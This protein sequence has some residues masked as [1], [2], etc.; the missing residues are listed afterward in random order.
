MVGHGL[1][2]LMEKA[3]G[4]DLAREGVRLFRERYPQIAVE[5]TEL[6]PGV[7]EVLADLE[8][9]G[10]VLAVAS[11]KPARFSRLILEAK[12][13]GE[14]FLVISGPDELTPPKPDPAMLRAMMGLA[15][16]SPAETLVVGDMEI[17]AEMAGP[18]GVA[19]FWSE[20][21]ADRDGSPG[22]RPT[23][24]RESDGAAPMDRGVDLESVPS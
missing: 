14:R 3:V 10:H 4:P 8:R 2:R 22:F 20:R 16:A 23:L 13:V 19:S 24:A 7:P 1:E 9:R 17:D 6:M 15:R 12:G 11:N 21:L 18:R 5:K